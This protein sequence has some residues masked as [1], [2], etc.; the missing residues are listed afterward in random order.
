[1]MDCAV[2]DGL[3]SLPAPQVA[4]VSYYRGREAEL[5]LTRRV[6]EIGGQA[7]LAG[8]EGFPPRGGTVLQLDCRSGMWLQVLGEH[9]HQVTAIDPSP[10]DL[11]VAAWRIRDKPVR[12]RVRFVER[13]FF[14]WEPDQRFDVVFFAAV[15][16]YVP[17]ALFERFWDLV[18]DC[19]KPG[20]RVF[21]IDELPAGHEEALP[22]ALV[23]AMEQF[24]KTDE[25]YRAIKVFYEPDEL[26]SRLTQLGWSVEIEQETPRLFYAA[27]TRATTAA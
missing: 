16:S 7:L 13:D 19:L 4:F 18:A 21:F 2:S 24:L 1:M 17:P 26:E 12:D 6:D 11:K 20:G 27:A 22:E 14:D 10:K 8:L 3:D 5:G 23:P 9:A 25:R 15:L